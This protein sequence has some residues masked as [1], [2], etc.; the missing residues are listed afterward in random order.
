MFKTQRLTALGT[1]AIRLPNEITNP[2]TTAQLSLMNIRR[3]IAKNNGIIP[4]E[5]LQKNL[6]VIEE[7][8]SE[9]AS[10]IKVLQEFS[11][12]AGFLKVRK[13]WQEIIDEGLLFL[14]DEILRKKIT[15]HRYKDKEN[16]LPQVIVEPNEMSE[17]LINLIIIA[18][19]PL[20]NFHSNLYIESDFRADDEM[21]VTRFR[22]LNNPYGPLFAQTI[23][24]P[25]EDSEI[26][27]PQQFMFNV[28]KEIIHN[29]YQ[30]TIKSKLHKDGMEIILTMPTGGNSV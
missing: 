25:D 23:F 10:G 22:S 24:R 20:R 16:Q 13:T 8:L 11:T 5:Q 17:V 18:V 12:K 19:G 21:I 6:S 26:V 1:M 2:L 27:T 30:G 9:V 4:L 7:R 29:N 15:I 14:S 28:A 3:K